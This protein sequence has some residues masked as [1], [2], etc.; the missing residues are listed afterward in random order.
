M[1]L[2]TPP[3]WL[4]QG[5]HPAENDRLT[6]QALFASTGTVGDTSL[7]VSAQAVPNMTVAVSAGW[8]SI[9]SSVTNG[10]VYVVYNDASTNLSITAADATNPRIDRV[11]VTVNDA[12]YSGLVN[13]CT[14]T[15]IAGTPAVSPTAPA[16]PANSISL[17][18]ILVSAGATSITSGSITSTRVAATSNLA[19]S[20]GGF[21]QFM[22]MG[23]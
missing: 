18:T 19:S 2:R 22:L 10:G 8:A 13:N 7:V 14:F 20:G 3:S 1:A 16:I 23:A 4:Q 17:A 21:D 12:Y 9:L 6:M 5:S 15:V 11:V